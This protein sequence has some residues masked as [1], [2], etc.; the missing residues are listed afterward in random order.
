MEEISWTT[1]KRKL[2]DLIPAGYNPRRLTPEDKVYLKASLEKFG[3]VEIPVINLDN[4]LLAGHQRVLIISEL[5][6]PELEIDVRVPNRQLTEEEAK[7]YNIRSNRNTGE[8]DWDLLANHFDMNTLADWGFKEIPFMGTEKIDTSGGDK[9]KEI[10]AY[11]DGNIRS[12]NI[13]MNKDEYNEAIPKL[14]QIMMDEGLEDITSVF[15]KMLK[16]YEDTE[17]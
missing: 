12:M 15:L 16:H 6:N 8:W 13:I 3:L 11:N 17:L 9:T 7:E 2:K 5:E 10:D 14:Q 4:V 1:Q